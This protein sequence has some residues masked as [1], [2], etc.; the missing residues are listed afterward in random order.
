M[1]QNTG[2][3]EPKAFKYPACW[4]SA[5]KRCY[6]HWMGKLGCHPFGIISVF[7][8]YIHCTPKHPWLVRQ[9]HCS[10]RVL[11]IRNQRITIY[12]E[13]SDFLIDSG[14][15]I[16]P[17]THVSTSQHSFW[18]LSTCALTGGVNIEQKIL[19]AGKIRAAMKILQGM[20]GHTREMVHRRF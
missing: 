9:K 8:S 10:Q 12:Q 13:L 5:S 15:D 6:H 14:T 19:Y 1:L 18:L 17:D 11:Y 3:T 4:F 2:L 7:Q 16:V 20:I